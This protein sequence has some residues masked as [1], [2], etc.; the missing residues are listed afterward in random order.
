MTTIIKFSRN[1]YT[2]EGVRS[3]VEQFSGFGIRHVAS[4]G[5]YFCVEVSDLN[6]TGDQDSLLD[7]FKNYVLYSTIIHDNI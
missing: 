4:Q 7:E 5:K 3:A 1:L 2:R 6:K